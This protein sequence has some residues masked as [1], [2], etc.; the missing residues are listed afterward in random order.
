M[1]L[2]FCQKWP[3]QPCHLLILAVVLWGLN[4]SRQVQQPVWETD[5]SDGREH[6]KDRKC[7]S[8]CTQACQGQSFFPLSLGSIVWSIS[9]SSHVFLKPSHCRTTDHFYT[10]EE[11]SQWLFCKSHT[12]LAS[13]IVEGWFFCLLQYLCDAFH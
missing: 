2:S 5:W 9:C 7:L 3:Q 1:C 12:F 11:L 6:M 8:Y 13:R 10:S 4:Y